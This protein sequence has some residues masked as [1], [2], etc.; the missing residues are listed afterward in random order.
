[1]FLFQKIASACLFLAAKVEEQPRKLELVI[2]SGHYFI[3]RGEDNAPAPPLDTKSQV[4]VSGYYHLLLCPLC[5]TVSF[6]SFAIT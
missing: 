3:N 2:K 5:V 1:M 4:S 6:F